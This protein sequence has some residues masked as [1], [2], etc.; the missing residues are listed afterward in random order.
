VIVLLLISFAIGFIC[1]AGCFDILEHPLAT[2]IVAGAIAT[3][4]VI[5]DQMR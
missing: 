3:L 2:F 5:L 1:D 4:L